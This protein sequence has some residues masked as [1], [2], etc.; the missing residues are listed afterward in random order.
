MENEILEILAAIKQRDTVLDL[1]GVCALT[2]LS[3]SH[4]YKLT[5]ARRIPFSK[6]PGGQKLYF[7][8]REIEHWLLRQNKV[9]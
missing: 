4:I 1:A 2:G 5:M 8:Q 6:L 7:S 3:R 9:A